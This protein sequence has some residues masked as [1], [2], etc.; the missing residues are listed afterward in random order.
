VATGADAAATG[1]SWDAIMWNAAQAGNYAATVALVNTRGSS[2]TAPV[3][4]GCLSAGCTNIGIFM[5]MASMGTPAAG[6]HHFNVSAGVGAWGFVLEK[7]DGTTVTA[8]ADSTTGKR[9]LTKVLAGGNVAVALV[10]GSFISQ[11]VIVRDANF[12][13]EPISTSAAAQPSGAA[14]TLNGVVASSSRFGKMGA[15]TT[16]NFHRVGRPGATNAISF[17]VPSISTSFFDWGVQKT[18][19]IKGYVTFDSSNVAYYPLLTAA[20]AQTMTLDTP[21]NGITGVNDDND[22]VELD[23]DVLWWNFTIDAPTTA[24]VGSNAAYRTGYPT[25]RIQENPTTSSFSGSSNGAASNYQLTNSK[26]A[27]SNPTSSSASQLAPVIYET[28]PRVFARISRNTAR[29][30]ASGQI[31]STVTLRTETVVGSCR[32]YADCYSTDADHPALRSR[33]SAGLAASRLRKCLLMPSQAEP[34]RPIAQCSECESDC[35]CGEGEYCHVD[36]GVC[37]NGVTGTYYTCDATSHSKFG[38][39]VAKDPT[40]KIIG[41]ACRASSGAVFSSSVDIVASTAGSLGIF[42]NRLDNGSALTATQSGNAFCGGVAYYNSSNTDGAN[43]N[44]ISR[45]SSA[46]TML[47]TGSCLDGVCY[48]CT[49]GSGSCSG[50]RTCIQ[51]RSLDTVVV[52]ST[53]RTFASNT[54][55]G[56]MLGATLMIVLALLVVLGDC[57]CRHQWRGEDIKQRKL[58]EQRR[59]AHHEAKHHDSEEAKSN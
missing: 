42:K 35:E 52:D 20:A 2:S 48:E 12:T 33:L 37:Q 13:Y 43:S 24:M 6:E 22:I 16:A 9:V 40:N 41:A 28:R 27:I 54:V 44:G 56:T 59:K 32:S 26:Y 58:N 4:N 21:S 23:L 15:V 25:V 55:A 18:P 30:P 31:T 51:G 34:T 11:R 29:Q 10:K 49:T 46:R 5:N 14:L 38:L 45:N 3:T 1:V 39:C 50:A 47:W 7:D 19:F 8:D 53:V 57:I 17:T 36:T